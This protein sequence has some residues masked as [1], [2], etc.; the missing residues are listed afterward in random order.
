[1]K[2]TSTQYQYHLD[3]LDQLKTTIITTYET[4]LLFGDSLSPVKDV[5]SK[6]KWEMVVVRKILDD[7]EILDNKPTKY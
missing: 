7:A 6:L 4:C 2:M 3:T 1:M 5:V